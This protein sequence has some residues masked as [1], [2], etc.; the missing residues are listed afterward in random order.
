M[1]KWIEAGKIGAETQAFAKKIAKPGMTLLEISEKI[2]NKIQELGAKTA[3][4]V[5]LSLNHVAAHYIA[6]P[7]DETIFEEED[8]LKIDIGTHIDGY[9]SDSAFT[10]SPN[11]ELVKASEEALKEAI[12]LATPGTK[13]TTIGKN[14]QEVI[15]SFGFQSIYNLSGH[16]IKQYNIHAGLTIP[17]YNNGNE[18]TLQE[19]MIIA[20]E[21]FATK[22]KGSIIE[23]KPSSIYRIQQLKPVR[24]PTTKKIINFIQ[25]EFK[26][27]PF[28]KRDILKQFPQASFNINLLLKQ[29]ILKEYAQL[30]EES[31]GLVSQAEHTV[32][33]KDKPITLTKRI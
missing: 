18:N 9:I 16:E 29:D 33:V 24:D 14:T 25:K 15:E 2:E 13:L 22:G 6:F 19:G 26:T 3:F 4:P 20:I 5:N 28:S 31:K 21:P 27:L 23:G 11:K 7:K 8:T 30:V 1:E 17:N 12:T 10:I 32:L